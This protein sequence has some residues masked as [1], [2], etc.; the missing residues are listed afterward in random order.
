VRYVGKSWSVEASL[1]QHLDDARRAA[2]TPAHRWMRV[3]LM[4]ERV[5]VASCIDWCEGEEDALALERQWIEAFRQAGAPLVN[6]HPAKEEE[7]PLVRVV[8]QVPRKVDHAVWLE[9]LDHTSES[10]EEYCI[11]AIQERI[12]RDARKAGRKQESELQFSFWEGRG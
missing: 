6:V 1:Q 2:D 10:Y 8:L 7:R 5:P 11:A 12:R 9:M 3:I 4:S